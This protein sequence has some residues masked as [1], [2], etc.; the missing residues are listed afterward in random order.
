MLQGIWWDRSLDSWMFLGI[1]VMIS[2]LA[3]PLS[4]EALNPFMVKSD[5]HNKKPFVN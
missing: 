1:D 2:I 5:P 3:S 4:R